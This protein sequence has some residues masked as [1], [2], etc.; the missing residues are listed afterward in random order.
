MR[1]QPEVNAP[2]PT[3]WHFV[4]PLTRAIS[5]PTPAH[6]PRALPAC[7]RSTEVLNT[8]LVGAQDLARQDVCLA[9]D[10]ALE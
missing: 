2:T 10:K 5:P 8:R 1:L 6:A 7:A 3:T 4:K 9:A